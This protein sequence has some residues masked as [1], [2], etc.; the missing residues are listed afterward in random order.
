MI[1][2]EKIRG[3]KQLKQENY[4]HKVKA[5]SVKYYGP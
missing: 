5:T 1:F 4:R 2:K 3:L